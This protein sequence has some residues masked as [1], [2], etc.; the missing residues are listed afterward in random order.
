MS[1]C[2]KCLGCNQLELKQFK[3]LYKCKYFISAYVQTK[4][5]QIKL[6]EI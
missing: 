3:E 6:E 5:E 2:K 4:T 1:L